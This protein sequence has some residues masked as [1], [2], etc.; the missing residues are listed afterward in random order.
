MTLCELITKKCIATH[1]QINF[2]SLKL[3]L[4]SSA[5]LMNS[6]RKLFKAKIITV[7]LKSNLL[8]NASLHI[9]PLTFITEALCLV[10]TA[11]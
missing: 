8:L 7:H 5:L 3:V 11:R 1:I 9:W 6:S 10:A 4:Y 2:S